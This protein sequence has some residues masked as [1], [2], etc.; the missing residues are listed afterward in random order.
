METTLCKNT[1]RRLLWCKAWRRALI[2][3]PCQHDTLTVWWPGV[4]R[5]L[6]C[7]CQRK[8]SLSCVWSQLASWPG[9]RLLW[10]KVWPPK[11]FRVD[12]YKLR[13][14]RAKCCRFT[15]KC[16]CVEFVSIPS[17]DIWKE[18]ESGRRF[19]SST[20]NYCK[21]K[22]TPDTILHGVT[23]LVVSIDGFTVI[24]PLVDRCTIFGI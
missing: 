4:V 8:G 3:I 10:S 23:Y 18:T 16:V 21:K 19:I 13:T 9:F 14:V 17:E 5:R 1:G 15:K 7:A 12:R 2:D 6:L 22:F 20:V 24:Y 11:S